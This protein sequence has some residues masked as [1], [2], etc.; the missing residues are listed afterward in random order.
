MNVSFKNICSL[1]FGL[2]LA[3]PA[4][5]ST[6]VAKSKRINDEGAKLIHDGLVRAGLPVTVS[7]AY[8]TVSSEHLVCSVHPLMGR[9][10]A[11]RCYANLKNEE[12]DI[13][14]DMAHEVYDTLIAAGITKESR[15]GSI[16]VQV[17]RVRCQVKDGTHVGAFCTV[18]LIKN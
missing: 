15:P 18:F 11:Y 3:M 14:D 17:G 16:G 12:F 13:P 1:A 6:P 10:I 5:G 4:F 8:S 7:G 9:G 2:M